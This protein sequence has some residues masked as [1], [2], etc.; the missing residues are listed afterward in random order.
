M[1]ENIEWISSLLFD[2]GHLRHFG[3]GPTDQEIRETHEKARALIL[4]C[5]PSSLRKVLGADHTTRAME[6]MVL[7]TQCQPLLMHLTLGVLDNLI[8]ELFPELKSH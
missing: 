5:L 2:N 7:F 4:D 1:A 6:R 8:L 3:P